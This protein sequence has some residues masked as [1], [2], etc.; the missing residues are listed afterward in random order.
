MDTAVSVVIP[1][2]N[3]ED[4]IVD[5]VRSIRTQR[6]DPA[7][8]EILLVDDDSTDR[9]LE[10]ARPFGVTPIRNG[11][12]DC[13]VG[14]AIGLRHA[15][16]R[17]IL[18][19]DAD[20]R[21][22]D[23]DWLTRAIGLLD[24][25]PHL[26]G[27]QSWKFRYDRAHNA[28]IRYHALWGNTDPM[29][30]Y[31]GGRDHLRQFEARWELAGTVVENAPDHVVVRFRPEELP[32]IGSQGFLTRRDYF[33]EQL[34]TFHHTEFYIRRIEQ[35]P[36]T[37]FAFLKCTVTHLAFDSVGDL[38]RMFKRNIRDY[39]RDS[40]KYPVKRY[41]LT[42]GRLVRVLLITQTGLVPLLDAFAGWRRIRDPAWFL[43]VWLA[44]VVPWVYAR[45]ILGSGSRGA[46][47][48]RVLGR[49]SRA[50]D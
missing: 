6:L 49:T 32:T 4:N 21:L 11:A 35:D 16:G 29:V 50:K 33:T 27:V 19:L 36:E 14:K 38:R 8:V 17:Y 41:D 10:L 31:L 46:V 34:E 1:V 15:R 3:E 25:R 42:P 18:F 9:T 43:H 44:F 47:I 22:D 45:R 39:L 48:R 24:A 12:R 23:P 2:Y 7:T 30:F 13:E 28:A 26:A 37:A 40:G 5:C 20:N